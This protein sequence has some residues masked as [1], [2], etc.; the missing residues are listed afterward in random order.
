[1]GLAAGSLLLLRGF[2]ASRIHAIDISA[3]TVADDLA[4]L[5]SAGALPSTLPVLAGQSAQVLTASGGVLAVSP[6]TLRTLPLVPLDQAITLARTGP[7]NVV[8]DAIDGQGLSRVLVRPVTVGPSREYVVVTAS[9]RDERDTLHGLARFVL[10]AAPVLLVVVAG[11]L[12]L[13]LGRA[14]G[15][16]SALRIAAEAVTEPDGGT[17]LPLPSSRDEIHALAVTLN[18][19]LDRLAAATVRERAFLADAAHELRSPLASMRA[20]LEV[21]AAHP[22]ST[23]SA[24]L[25]T[26]TLQ[27]TERLAALV[28]DLL[29][30]A[31]LEAGAWSVE[32]VVDIAE[33]AGVPG[34]GPHLVRGDPRGLARALANLVANARQHARGAVEVTVIRTAA[35][36][37]E[38][39]VDDD[40]PGIAAAD[41][42]RVFERF[43]RLDDSRARADGGSGLGLAIVRATV[44]AHGGTVTATDS[45]LG[46]ARFVLTFPAAISPATDQAPSVH[47]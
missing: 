17:R 5:A 13:L 10:V 3:R 4:N 9:L 44:Q 23:S 37:I 2:A 38:V 41:R 32:T 31:R 45:P 47:R 36:T 35:K 33:L 16:V 29:V 21:A 42:D 43:V 27:E 6:G 1:M 25:A 28:D 24:E 39:H 15:T 19:M 46:G 40:G 8:V 30:L 11:M 18:A 7:R 34:Q 12:W 22:D 20:Q 14:L 26:G